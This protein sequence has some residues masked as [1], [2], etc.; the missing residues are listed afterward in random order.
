M[1]YKKIGDY[2]VIGDGATVA[3]IGRDG[4]LDWLC[5]PFMDSPS[6]FAAILD[7][8]TGGRFSISPDA[9]CDSSQVYLPRTL[10][11]YRKD[12]GAGPDAVVRA[13]A[14]RLNR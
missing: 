1:P 3:L 5:L 13:V 14:R 8:G 7:D 10:R 6:V 11:W 4:A 12:F 9:P 2:G